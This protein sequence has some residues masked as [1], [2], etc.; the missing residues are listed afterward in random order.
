MN[1]VEILTFSE[2]F[3]LVEEDLFEDEADKKIAK[4]ILDAERDWRTSIHSLSDFITLLETEINGLASESNLKKLGE[5]YSRNIEKYAWESE[6][7]SYLL[8][9]F[10]ITKETELEKVFIQLSEKVPK[11]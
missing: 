10:K 9:I 8:D 5:K 2:L 1:K 4:S 11:K 6:S 7:I 3:D